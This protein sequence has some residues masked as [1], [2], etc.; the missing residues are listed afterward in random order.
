MASIDGEKQSQLRGYCCFVHKCANVNKLF[1]HCRLYFSPS[2]LVDVALKS[3]SR[4]WHS[5]LPLAIQYFLIF[6]ETRV[7]HKP[8]SGKYEGLLRLVVS[9][10]SS[11]Q[12]DLHSAATSAVVST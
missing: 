1:W 8:K 10:W 5:L 12:T 3:A 11:S 2:N 4:F 9:I 6:S 7:G